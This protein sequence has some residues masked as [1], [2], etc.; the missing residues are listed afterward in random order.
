MEFAE[1]RSSIL[2]FARRHRGRG[3]DQRSAINCG[4]VKFKAKTLTLG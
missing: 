3:L 1:L 2:P 4:F